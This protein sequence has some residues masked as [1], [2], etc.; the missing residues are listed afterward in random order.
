MELTAA[1]PVEL[2]ASDAGPMLHA[3]IL[4][5]GRVARQ[6]AELFAPSSVYWP[7]DGIGIKL[8][9][10]RVDG[11]G[12]IVEAAPVELR[13]IPERAPDGSLTITAPATPAA[14]AAYQ[15]GRRFLSV[16]FRADDE[17]RNAAGVREIRRALV[18]NVAMTDQPEY[19]QARVEVRETEGRPV[20]L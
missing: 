20:W 1:A 8:R 15:A 10:D 12:R 5:E 14:F 17:A 2:R 18:D 19:A 13:A 6:R 3:T 9:H 16:Q 11:A 7:S 4:Q